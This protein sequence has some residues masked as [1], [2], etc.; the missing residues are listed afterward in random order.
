MPILVVVPTLAARMSVSVVSP[1]EVFALGGAAP[2]RPL[3]AGIAEGG[4]GYFRA[5]ALD[6]DGTLA[7]GVVALAA[8][9]EARAQGGRVILVTGRIMS[10][11]RDVFPEVDEHVDAVVAENGA[12]LVTHGPRTTPHMRHEH[13][14]G[15]SGVEPVRRFYFRTEPGTPTGAVAANLA[16]LEAELGC[17]D[18]GVLRHHCPRHDFSGWVV[19]VSATSASPATSPPPKPP[20]RPR[21]TPWSSSRYAWHSSPHSRPA[22]QAE[23]AVPDCA[24]VPWRDACQRCQTVPAGLSPARETMLASDL[25]LGQ[26][27]PGEGF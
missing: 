10:E 17:C 21:A 14:Y 22:A 8:L 5:V 6:Y 25:G 3:A 2:D 13:K 23:P 18:P 20:S 12:L 24:L 16:E 27:H 26:A 7:D 19:G 9:A 15:H 1:E 4:V 11:L